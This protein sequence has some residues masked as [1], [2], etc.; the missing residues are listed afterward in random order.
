MNHT[1]GPWFVQSEHPA[2][3]SAAVNNGSDS[4]VST[5]CGDIIL[6]C[7]TA[8]VRAANARLIA[9]APELLAA[10]IEMERLAAVEMWDTGVMKPVFG[11]ALAAARAAIANAETCHGS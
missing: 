2:N 10:L 1:P 5:P 11:R 4:I 6:L 7:D 8:R 9:A 3:L